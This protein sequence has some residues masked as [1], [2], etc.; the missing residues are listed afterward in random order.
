[1]GKMMPNF[2]GQSAQYKTGQTTY[3]CF[4]QRKIPNNSELFVTLE[5]AVFS[6][7]LYFDEN[8]KAVTIDAAEDISCE[9]LKR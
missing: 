8:L 7:R 9:S 5:N 4:C 6:L 3:P 1:M 2:F